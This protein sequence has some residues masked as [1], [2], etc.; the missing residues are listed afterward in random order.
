M[1][2][3]ENSME[4]DCYYFIL[5]DMNILSEKFLFWYICLYDFYFGDFLR[6]MFWVYLCD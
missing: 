3:I 5:C 1:G 4:V 6:Y 2:F